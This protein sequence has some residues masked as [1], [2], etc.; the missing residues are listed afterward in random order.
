MTFVWKN[1]AGTTLKTESAVKTSS[2]ETLVRDTYYVEVSNIRGTTKS[3]EVTLGD[4]LGIPAFVFTAI[5]TGAQTGVGGSVS[6]NAVTVIGSGDDIWNAADGFEYAYI[7]VSGDGTLTARVVSL[8]TTNTDGWSKSG[9]MFRESLN[10][11]S[12]YAIMPVIPTTNTAADIFQYRTTTG[13]GAAAGGTPSLHPGTWVRVTRSGSNFTGYYS[14]DGITF[15]QHGT[16]AI[17]MTADPIYVGLAVSC[18]QHS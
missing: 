11:N 2:Y 16:V 18:S 12:T 1:A 8:D 15:T 9:V 6:G 10:A 5:G 7:P 4:D 17:T 14:A 3:N 13:G